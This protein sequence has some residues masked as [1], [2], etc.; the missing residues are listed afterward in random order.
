MRSA[1]CKG[2]P[3]TFLTLESFGVATEIEMEIVNLEG[4]KLQFISSG[5]MEVQR[6]DKMHITRK[7]AVMD[8]EVFLSESVLSIL[9]KNVGAYLQISDQNSIDQAINTIEFALDFDAAGSDFLADSH[10]GRLLAGTV[11]GTHIGMTAVGGQPAHRLAF[12]TEM[13]DWQTWIAHSDT[14]LPIKD[15]I[16]S[17]WATGAPQLVSA[18]GRQ[19]QNSMRQY[20]NSSQKTKSSKSRIF[21]LVQWV[22]FFAYSSRSMKKL[23]K[24][25]I[26][27]SIVV[28][29]SLLP[30][31]NT[32]ENI[33][34]G[35]FTSTAHAVIGR[36][37][38]PGSVAGLSRR[39]TRRT[40]RRTNH[41]VNTLP[42]SCTTVVVDGTSLWL[43][44]STYYQLHNSQYVVVQ[45]E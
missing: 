38:T 26:A 7:G 15:L 24:S 27:I 33:S 8:A 32:F 6:P 25:A 29:A 43:C 11:S 21:R 5:A 35:Y 42:Q 9:G 41:Y 31:H 37:A 18:T 3:I 30:D 45:V 13:V 28:T 12:R 14:P 34:N 1:S 20:S 2:C 16:T 23:N 22:Q 10:Y 40:I 4:Q 44:G 36:P 19:I 17:I 39:A